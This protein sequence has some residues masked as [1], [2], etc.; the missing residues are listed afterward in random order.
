MSKLTKLKDVVIAIA[1]ELIVFSIIFP[2]VLVFRD[3]VA[4]PLL[5]VLL[6]FPQPPVIILSSLAAGVMVI[7]AIRMVRKLVVPV[8]GT[9]IFVD[10]PDYPRWRLTALAGLFWCI[11]MGVLLV[12]GAIY[13]DPN[14]NHLAISLF[15]AALVSGIVSVGSMYLA[16]LKLSEI[17]NRRS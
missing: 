12:L 5:S 16:D 2:V 15:S 10:W 9:S 7:P 3:A 6:S 17:M 11:A 1:P 4:A 13:L 8:D 14:G